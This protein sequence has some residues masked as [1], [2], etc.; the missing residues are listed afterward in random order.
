MRAYELI[1]NKIRRWRV[2]K[3]REVVRD[4]ICQCGAKIITAGKLTCPR[5]HQSVDMT[6]ESDV[7]VDGQGR[8]KCQKCLEC[9]KKPKTLA[10]GDEIKCRQCGAK[11]SLIQKEEKEEMELTCKEARLV[12]KVIDINKKRENMIPEEVGAVAHYFCCG[13]CKNLG[14]N[15]ILAKKITCQEALEIWAAKP[16]PRFLCGTDTLKEELA[17]EH[18]WGRLGTRRLP[19]GSTVPEPHLGACRKDPCTKLRMYWV[20]APLSCAYDGEKETAAQIPFLIRVFLEENW[21]LEK[22]LEIQYQRMETLLEGLLVGDVGECRG[23]YSRI[24]D[25]KQEVKVNIQGLQIILLDLKKEKS[26]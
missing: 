3:H 15:E 17:V 6:F 1:K 4:L 10:I 11:N 9:G 13:E 7:V 19:S 21:P 18:I 23:I 26:K 14:L 12:L 25:L 16:G 24:E 20:N 22:L 8:W 2:P 5:C